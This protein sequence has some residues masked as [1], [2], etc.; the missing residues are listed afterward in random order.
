MSVSKFTRFTSEFR[1]RPDDIDMNQHVHNSTYLDYVLAAR[2]D[3]MER[4]YGMSMDE[5]IAMGFGW[6][7]TKAYI[8]YKRALK[9]GD[10]FTVT[11]GI[12]TFMSKGVNVQFEIK[13]KTTGKTCCLG[14]M[15]YT[16]IDT[17]SGKAVPLPQ[18]IVQKYSV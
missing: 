16:I 18:S 10:Y 17:K 9:M 7:Q 8:E 13:N 6:V 5:F 14:E 11:T 3:Q 4:C 1:V 15:E 12:T 2:Y